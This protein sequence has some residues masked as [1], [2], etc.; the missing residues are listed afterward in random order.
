MPLVDVLPPGAPAPVDPAAEPFSDVV[1]F[2][3]LL[4]WF[5]PAVGFVL[6]ERLP[7]VELLPMPVV[8]L[9]LVPATEPQGWPLRPV[10][11]DVEE[12]FVPVPGVVVPGMDVDPALPESPEPLLVPPL[13][14]A[15]PPLAPPPLWAKAAAAPP[16]TT[17]ATTTDRIVPVCLIAS[18]PVLPGFAWPLPWSTKGPAEVSAHA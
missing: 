11:P 10:V 8:E 4:V 7:F 12:L 3:G 17:A 18:T 14:P 13:A 9:P 15:L 5:V 2:G 6:E 1:L 16:R